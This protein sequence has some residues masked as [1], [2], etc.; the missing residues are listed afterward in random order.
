MLAR[1]EVKTMAAK[2]KKTK[3]AAKKKA[4]AAKKAP[5]KKKKTKKAAAAKTKAVAKAPTKTARGAAK[6]KAGSS[7]GKKQTNLSDV[8]KEVQSLLD[9]NDA[10]MIDN[11]FDHLGDMYDID[12][13]LPKT[14]KLRPA[15]DQLYA[16]FMEI[17]EEVG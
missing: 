5:A 3:A 2:K 1:L 11:V 16:E 14:S 10:G 17:A 12:K 6:P 4:P 7:K 9:E 13:R 15:F 8:E